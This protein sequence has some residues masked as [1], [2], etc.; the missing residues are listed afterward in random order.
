[1]PPLVTVE[2]P[3]PRATA[4]VGE[5]T[6]I[7]L[8]I[9]RPADQLGAV[10][11]PAIRPINATRIE[12]DAD[13]MQQELTISPGEVYTLSLD[14]RFRDPGPANLNELL[15]QANPQRSHSDAER[16]LI[17]LPA[18]PVRVVPSLRREIKVEVVRICGY[19]AKGVKVEL[20]AR[21]I[22]TTHW[23]DFEISVGPPDRVRAGITLRREAEF[24]PGQSTT[25]E[26]VGTGGSLEIGL[27]AHAPD[28]Q[29]VEDR[30][31]HE[32]PPG[33]DRPATHKQYT[34]LEPRSLTTDRITIEPEA[35]GDAI[36]P[37]G[38]VYPVHGGKSRYLVTIHPSRPDPREVK[39]FP[40]GG[41]VEVERRNPDAK[42]AGWQFLI[43]VVE[44]PV[45]TQSVR[46]F[47]DVKVP[48]RVL[49]GELHL[50]IRPTSWKLWSL[51][52]TAG[53]AL[54]LKGITAVGPV[55]FRGDISLEEFLTDTSELLHQRWFDLVQLGSIFVVRGALWIADRAVRPF[56]EG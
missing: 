30:Q 55:L 24:R 52:I 44:N 25:Y 39:L 2:V 15:I 42:G 23:R 43:T 35:G 51:A 13:L 21:H 33:D 45:L 32:I 8:L 54:T 12:V 56:H 46:L 26:V 9:R 27:A 7:R 3:E 50:S 5:A 34:F 11:I 48:D 18:Q 28:G 31:S 4:Q 53:A 16:E 10:T 40:A 20:R 1:M 29:R 22:G 17:P 36:V 47:Y 41:Q 14:V 6:T 49:R 38:G 19:D 37:R